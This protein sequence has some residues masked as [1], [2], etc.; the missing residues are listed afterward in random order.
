MPFFPSVNENNFFRYK[1]HTTR[2]SDTHER[3]QR[4]RNEMVAGKTANIPKLLNLRKM[5]LYISE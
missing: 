4:R 5:T 1:E 3:T 2:L